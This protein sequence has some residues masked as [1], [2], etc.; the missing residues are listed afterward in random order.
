MAKTI[1]LT[2]SSRSIKQAIKELKEY[3]NDLKKKT[4]LFVE[5]LAQEGFDVANATV[6]LDL[7]FYDIGAY[8]AEVL[9]PKV[10]VEGNRVKATLTFQGDDILFIEFGTGIRYSSISHPMLGDEFP[11]GAGTYP[12]KGHWDNPK[13]WWYKDDVTG[14]KVHTY[15]NPA[16]MPMYEASTMIQLRVKK[17]AKEVFK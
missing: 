3:E 6:K 4:K 8:D 5:R 12:G 10:K 13:G 2:L 14:E 9:E 11:Y 17:I 7:P 15:G 1:N 16:L